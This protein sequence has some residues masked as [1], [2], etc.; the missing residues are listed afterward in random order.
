MGRSVG[1]RGVTSVSLESLPK[2]STVVVTTVSPSP[3]RRTGSDE[4]IAVW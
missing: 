2:A 1:F 3:I 4:P